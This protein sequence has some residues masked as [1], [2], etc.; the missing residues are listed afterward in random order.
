MFKQL[1]KKLVASFTL[2]CFTIVTMSTSIEAIAST[3]VWIAPPSG[4]L[5]TWST[6]AAN[7]NNWITM[8]NQKGF[9]MVI[10]YWPKD[11]FTQIGSMSWSPDP[12]DATKAT[13]RWRMLDS[14]KWMRYGREDIGM[15]GI[16]ANLISDRINQFPKT[17]AYV[18]A[19]Y[20]PDT[21]QLI[22]EVQKIE[23][24][25]NGTLAV[26]RA[27]FTPWHGEF[28]KWKRDYLTPSEELNPA[29]MGY[30]PFEKFKGKNADGSDNK[31]DHV[32]H[33]I[34]W[35]AAGVAIGEAMKRY[36]AHVGWIAS[37]K[38]R[39]TQR[40]KKSGGAFKKKVTVY[41]DGWA[42]PQWFVAMPL[43]HQPQGGVSAICV[44]SVGATNTYGATASCDAKEH[45]ALSGVSIQAWEGGNMPETEEKVYA[46]KQSKSG[47]TVLAFTILTFAVT[48]GM[49]AALS[50]VI[51]AGLGSGLSAVTTASIGAGI[52]A[53]VAMLS[54]AGLTTAQ[55]NW[56]GETGDGV[57]KV[58]TSGMDRHQQGLIQGVRNL[59]I[60]SRVGTG[61]AGGKTLYSGNCP[62][63]Y[64]VQQCWDAGKD[65]GTMHRADIY[66]ETNTTLVLAD[67]KERCEAMVSS[68]DYA[69][70]ET[71]PVLKENLRKW[72]QQCAAPKN[73]TWD[74][75]W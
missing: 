17:A 61:L 16:P 52:Y 50:G 18:F 66:S 13:L 42:K 56:A 73:G 15:A 21:A 49:A 8:P 10:N 63:N 71:D 67:E 45:V 57:L 20:S 47:F 32:F 72:I 74:T 35:E 37:D 54:G 41:I 28:N 26:Y 22:I 24:N 14:D 2:I 1:F 58:N 11:N 4:A 59:Q 25:P 38:T 39:F 36:D 31:Q 12:E 19:N 65:P 33:N 44:T 69:A 62:E 46:F 3:S 30:N 5:P 6:H 48:W 9:G 55:S 43:G 68:T 23:K 27:D 51:G 60:K 53:G 75:G 34:S 70:A 64:T 7:S 40:T 29:K